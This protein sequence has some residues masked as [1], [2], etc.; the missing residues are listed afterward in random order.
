MDV[1]SYGIIL[2][3]L[4]HTSNP[5]MGGSRDAALS[6]SF[7]SKLREYPI[8]SII[9]SIPYSDEFKIFLKT[10]LRRNPAHRPSV[11]TFHGVS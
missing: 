9:D 5:I 1:W 11:T 2:L 7:K 10:I 3:E 6:L 4:A 8:Y